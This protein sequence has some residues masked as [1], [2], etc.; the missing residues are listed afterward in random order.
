M[1]YSWEATGQGADQLTYRAS[2][3]G[4]AEFDGEC[5]NVFQAMLLLND[6][7]HPLPV[8]SPYQLNL[9]GLAAGTYTLRVKGILNG[10]AVAEFDLSYVNFILTGSSE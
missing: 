10:E 6:P 8:S 3:N 4:G 1:S 2:L 9:T 7:F 5:A